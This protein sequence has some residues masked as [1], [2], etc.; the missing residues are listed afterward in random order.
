MHE[1]A[2]RGGRLP[3]RVEGGHGERDFAFLATPLN[4][5]V[6]LV[7]QQGVVIPGL[8]AD[9]KGRVPIKIRIA[10]PILGGRLIKSTVTEVPD[11]PV[12][13]LHAEPR[14]RRQG[15][16]ES[17]YDLCF[18]GSKHRKLAAGVDFSAHSGAKTA[19][20]PRIAVEG[21]GPAATASLRSAAGRR[22]A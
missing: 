7:Q 16:L 10:T 19:S 11:L 4:G 14:R 3:G 6:Y 12:G 18:S 13:Q 20:K 5:P 8:V 17:K 1:R 9:L 21:C 22:G 15:V 2:A